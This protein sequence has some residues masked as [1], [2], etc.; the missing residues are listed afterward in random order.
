MNR[1]SFL[2]GGAFGF[3]ISAARLSDYE[4]IHRMLRLQEFDVFLLMACAIGTA[5]PILWWLNRRQWHTPLGGDL[6]LVRAPVSRSNVLGA[7]MFGAGWAV[8]GTCPVPV[9]AMTAS[10]AGLGLAVGAGLFGGI[11]L[12]DRLSS[13]RPNEPT[14]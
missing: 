13:A 2:V 9:L 6:A 1:V 10:G 12:R 11:V 14:C 8:A 7:A 5:A 4:V 3:L